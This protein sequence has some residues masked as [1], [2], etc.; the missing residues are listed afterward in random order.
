M[1]QPVNAVHPGP[2]GAVHLG[3]THKPFA[4]GTHICLVFRDEA[5]RRAIVSKFVQSGIQDGE[6]VAYYADTIEPSELVKHMTALD[7]DP[8]SAPEVSNL[9]IEQ[10]ADAYCPDGQFIPEAMYDSLRAFYDQSKADGFP[11]ARVSGEMSWALRPIPGSERL[12]EYES[13]VNSVLR[14]HPITAMCQYDANAF[15]GAM[16]YQALQ[17]H[18]YLVLDGQLIKSPY[19]V[20]KELHHST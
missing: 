18:P 16:I 8:A 20:L 10:A 12:M 4:A 6:R 1:C 13:G 11:N 3:F 19:Y 15:S 5:E 7:I 17:V 2:V 9:R 14:T